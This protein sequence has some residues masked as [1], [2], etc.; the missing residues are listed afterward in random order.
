MQGEIQPKMEKNSFFGSLSFV[1][2]M[3]LTGDDKE[4]CSCEITNIPRSFI[5]PVKI[6]ND[7]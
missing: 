2:A 3:I 4:M 6:G 7:K 5:V 1:P